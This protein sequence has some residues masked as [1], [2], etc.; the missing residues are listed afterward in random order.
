MSN[1]ENIINMNVQFGNESVNYFYK[2]GKL[3]K[4]QYDQISNVIRSLFGVISESI[5]NF[6]TLNETVRV[7]KKE[8][9]NVKHEHESANLRKIEI[10]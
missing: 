7:L 4:E 3:T 6:N 1:D 10:S 9:N 5:K 8:F 2:Q